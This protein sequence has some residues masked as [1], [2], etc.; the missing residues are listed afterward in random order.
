MLAVDV[1]N[2]YLN[3]P[4]KEH[5]YMTAGL[6][7]GTSNLNQPSLI[8][9]AIYDLKSSDARWMEHISLTLYHMGFESCQAD[10]YVYLDI[11]DDPIPNFVNSQYQNSE[12]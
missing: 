11:P 5:C 2:A 12:F 1:Q 8:A 4:T 9:C 6:E 10:P 7:W 3:T